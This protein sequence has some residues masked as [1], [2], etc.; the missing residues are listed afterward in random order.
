MEAVESLAVKSED[1][2]GLANSYCNQALILRDWGHLD[3]AMALHWKQEAICEE[4]GDRAG[5]ANSYG[6]Q[7]LILWAWGRLDDAIALHKKEEA[8]CRAL[9]LSDDLR[10][11]LANQAVALDALNRSDEATACKLSRKT[12]AA[13]STVTRPRPEQ[14]ERIILAVQLLAHA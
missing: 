8:I 6:N 14:N 10:I 5:L 2:V 7:A 11:N 4:L 3:D 13:K 9:K 12:S 1:R